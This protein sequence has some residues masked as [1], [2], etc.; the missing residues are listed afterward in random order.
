MA[1]ASRQLS[2]LEAAGTPAL[3]V[4]FLLAMEAQEKGLCIYSS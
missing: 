3:G 1:E 4:V 2:G